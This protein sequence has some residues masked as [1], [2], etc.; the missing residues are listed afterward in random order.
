MSAY[1]FDDLMGNK[2][3]KPMTAGTNKLNINNI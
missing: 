2:I 3:K 1:F